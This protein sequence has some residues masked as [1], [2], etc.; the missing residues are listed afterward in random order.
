M[1]TPENSEKD[2]QRI[3]EAL[4]KN[5]MEYR[6][7]GPRTAIRCKKAITIRNAIFAP[8]KTIPVEEAVGAICGSPTVAC[9]PA[10]PIVVS[11]EVISK[12]AVDTFIYYGINTVDV[13][14]E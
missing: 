7:L 3:V 4:G 1:F 9:P 11:G 2:Y 6:Q 13:V 8:H 10:I 5:V 12:E 14:E